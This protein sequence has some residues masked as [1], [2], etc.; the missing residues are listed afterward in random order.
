MATRPEHLN[1]G[2]KEYILANGVK[3]DAD[4]LWAVLK[5]QATPV[6]G[7]VIDTT[8]L[9]VKVSVSPAGKTGPAAKPSSFVVN[10]KA[11]TS[12][13]D[14]PASADF[15]TQKAFILTSGV[16]SETDK[17]TALLNDDSKGALKVVI[18]PTVSVV[19][20]AVT[21]DAKTAKVA[22]FIVNLKKP[23]EG[24]E[25]PAVGYEYKIPPATS[26]VGT[27]SSYSQVA[28]TATTAQAALIVLSD[29]EVQLAEVK[30]PAAPAHKPAAGKPAA[31]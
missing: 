13:K 21:D 8:V 4:K 17:L 18:E 12:V 15:S 16:V 1:L 7:I 22:D 20:V 24:K 29:G 3:E 5:D 19:K 26:L 9:S 6:P 27:Y 2:D 28:A 23:L 14:I 31:H 10:L 25:I 30:K 11:P